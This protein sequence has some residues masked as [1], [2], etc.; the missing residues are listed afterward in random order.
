MTAE[1]VQADRWAAIRVAASQWRRSGFIDDA[2]LASVNAAHPDDRSRTG[3]GLRILFFL[4]T[5][6]VVLAAGVLAVDIVRGEEGVW[7]VCVVLG[8]LLVLATEWQIGRLRRADGGIEEATAL[9]AAFTLSVGWVWLLAVNLIEKDYAMPRAVV[10]GLMY[11]G[12][13]VIWSATAWRWGYWF[14]A[15]LAALFALQA[16]AQL[17][18]G[19]WFWLAAGLAV[20]GLTTY[21]LSNPIA[22]LRLSPSHRRSLRAVGLLGAI[23]VYLA[24]W[25]VSWDLSLLE[26][27]GVAS[28]IDMVEGGTISAS[29]AVTVG[30]GPAIVRVLLIV[31]TIAWPAV[32]LTL[33]ARR[34]LREFLALGAILAAADIATVRLYYAL[35]PAWI[36]LVLAGGALMFFALLVRRWLDAGAG[37][38][39][40]GVTTAPLFEPRDRTGGLELAAV[41]A[42]FAPST[43]PP[44][45]R[46]S[47]FT[48]G[49]GSAGGGGAGQKVP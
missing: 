6:L 9:M 45:P 7:I 3:R 11:G 1:T 14:H 46:G 31:A 2:A 24:V 8:A 39:R 34:R 42:A 29:W 41:A 4:M 18:G 10:E 47:D 36:C 44:G 40:G 16:L 30:R 5:S 17:P 28:A 38:E 37:G 49:G 21:L 33:G 43:A 25:I 35:L 48:P 12:C 19:R 13:C 15:L 32:L 27:T 26:R 23:A 22:A 20:T